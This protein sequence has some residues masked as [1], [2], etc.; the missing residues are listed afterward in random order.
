M[1]RVSRILIALVALAF[2]SGFQTRT[3]PSPRSTLQPK[4]TGLLTIR[5]NQPSR[6]A[7]ETL[8]EIAGIQV[9]FHRQFQNSAAFP[10]NVEKVDIF[11]AL[12]LLSFQTG[13]FWQVND[14]HT[15]IVATDNPTVRREVEPMIMKTFFLANVTRQQD[16]TELITLL[17]TTLSLSQI[18]VSTPANAIIIRDTPNKIALVERLLLNSGVITPP[19]RPEPM[20]PTPSGDGGP[21][22]A[23]QIPR[24]TAITA[25]DAGNV[26]IIDS[27]HVRK[28][29]TDG[30]IQAVHGDSGADL[31]AADIAADAAGNLYVA[32]DINH[33][34]RKVSTS[35]A[36]TTIAGTG[37]PGFSG[38]GGP[39]VPARLSAPKKIAVDRNGNIYIADSGNGRIRKIAAS[40]VITT[41]AGNGIWGFAGDGGPALSA[42][43]SSVSGLAADE[44]GN[45]FFGDGSSRV[46]K[47]TPTGIISTFAGTGTAGSS[48]DG[49]QAVSAQIEVADLA[50]DRSGNVFI[51]EVNRIRKVAPEG[52][53]RTVAGSALPGFSGDNGPAVSARL[54]GPRGIAANGAGAVFI[55]DTVNGRIRRIAPDGTISTIAGAAP[56]AQP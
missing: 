28:I 30:V 40:G 12:D 4:V 35:G 43:L 29:T 19:A 11:D 1:R 8:A 22:T 3:D 32:D 9:V 10:F 36:V 47:V 18:S 6:Q 20:P 42:R 51:V 34:V 24:A 49:G 13:N 38:D 15:I 50:A 21:A 39:A 54:R 55:A 16:I 53:I 23:A 44:A 27:N 41:I 5:M 25:D 46:R 2:T 7:Y 52:T 37:N 56:L 33:R 48:G 14:A 17:R 45:V 31:Y 26:F